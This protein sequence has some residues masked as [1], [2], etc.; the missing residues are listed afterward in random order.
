VLGVTFSITV[1]TVTGIVKLRERL[2]RML[3]DQ[4]GH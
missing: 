3:W 2:F 4:K 1:N